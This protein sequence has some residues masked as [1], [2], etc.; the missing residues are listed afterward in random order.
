MPEFFGPIKKNFSLIMQESAM[1]RESLITMKKSKFFN[2]KLSASVFLYSATHFMVNFLKL[3]VRVLSKK[4]PR[5]IL[6]APRIMS[7]QILFDTRREKFLR[8][9]LHD[10]IDVATFEKIFVAEEYCTEKLSRNTDVWRYYESILKSGS[11]PLVIDCGGNI[12]LASRYLSDTY[13]SAKVLCIEPDASNIQQAQTNNSSQNIDFIHAAVGCKDGR[14][15]IV[16]VGLGNNAYRIHNLSSGETKIISINSL[17]DSEDYCEMVPFLIKIDIEGFEKDLFSEN[18][19]WLKKFPVLI[20]ELHDW[21]LPGQGSA[22]KFLQQISNLD[23]DFVIVGENVF[24]IDNQIRLD[25][26]VIPL[27]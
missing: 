4:S 23:R 21:M 12:G 3:M 26:K 17:I 10:K 1:P 27:L 5:Y 6:L 8:I 20:I 13:E 25:Q 24:S 16:D 2:Q 9:N 18:I 14:G 19:E 11:T 7:R 15:S 22:Q